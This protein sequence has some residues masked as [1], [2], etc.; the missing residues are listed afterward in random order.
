MDTLRLPSPVDS[1]DG[2]GVLYNTDYVNAPKVYYC[3]SH[4]GDKP[5]SKYE[6]Y[7]NGLPGEILSNYHYRGEGPMGHGPNGHQTR[8]LD[9]ID[10]AQ[11][12]LLADGMQ[13]RSDYNHK[14]GANF[15]RAD[16][17]V[18]WFSDPSA[19]V[20]ADLPVTKEAADNNLGYIPLIW[21][22]LDAA[23]NAEW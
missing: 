9:F 16:L 22:R 8:N 20:P 6:P 13:L 17:S 4:R 12:S 21:T 11:S 18:H 10:P 23:A 14:V 15:F 7:F 1:W 2:L 3:P 19:T 5:W